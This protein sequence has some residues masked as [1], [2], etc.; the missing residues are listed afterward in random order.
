MHRIILSLIAILFISSSLA[1]A[2]IAPDP[3]PDPKPK[4]RQHVNVRMLA[5]PA[6]YVDLTGAD[7]PNVLELPKSLIADLTP[8]DAAGEAPRSSAQDGATRMKTIVAGVAMSAAVA[9]L[10]MMLVRRKGRSLPSVLITGG[11]IGLAT[12]VLANRAPPAMADKGVPRPPVVE[13]TGIETHAEV[14]LTDAGQPIVLRIDRE[15]L[16]KLLDQ[17]D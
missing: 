10:G 12:V 4:P 17:K 15:T 2:D 3:R 9:S 13:Q 11:V 7:E 5:G 14:H 6:L 1:S 8:G 16:Q